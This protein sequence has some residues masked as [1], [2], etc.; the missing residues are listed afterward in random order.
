M[1]VNLLTFLD[2]LLLLHLHLTLKNIKDIGFR[3]M[4]MVVVFHRLKIF[5][6]LA[7]IHYLQARSRV[8][9]QRDRLVLIQRLIEIEEGVFD[10]HELLVSVKVEGWFI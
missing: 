4:V 3:K 9:F 10:L 7:C 5:K 2:P 1:L 8:L 6:I